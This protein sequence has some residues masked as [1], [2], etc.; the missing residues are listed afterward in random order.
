MKMKVSVVGGS[1]ERGIKHVCW[2]GPG[3][4]LLPERFQAPLAC[5]CLN[6]TEPCYLVQIGIDKTLESS[7]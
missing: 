5:R 7:E 2:A 3:I 6:L 4:L 1:P